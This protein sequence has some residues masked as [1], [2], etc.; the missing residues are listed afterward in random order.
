[1]ACLTFLA[2][3]YIPG[4]RSKQDTLIVIINSTPDMYYIHIYIEAISESI[5]K[6]IR[7]M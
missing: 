6:P 1:M 5:F 2:Y 3:N 4:H 7:L